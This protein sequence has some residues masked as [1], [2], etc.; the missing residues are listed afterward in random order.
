MKFIKSLLWVLFIMLVAIL[1]F[2]ITL[3]IVSANEEMKEIE[4][5]KNQVIFKSFIDLEEEN[6]NN[7]NN[8]E[9]MTD[10]VDMSNFVNVKTDNFIFIGGSRFESLKDLSDNVDFNFIEFITSKDFDCDWLRNSALNDLNKLLHNSSESYN[11]V[12]NIGI[13]DFENVDRY[14]QFLNELADLHP[15]H[16]VFVVDVAPLDEYKFSAYY[17]YPINNDDIYNFNISLKKSLNQNVKMIYSYK[18]LIINGYNS[19][20]GY[21][22][23]KDTSIKLLQFI[24]DTILSFKEYSM[25][26]EEIQ[27]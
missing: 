9:N 26:L 27:E 7:T 8:Q 13:N 1:T 15:N 4:R 17:N 12:F 21:Y 22:F 14:A 25:K 3:E 10:V 11:I 20:D 16:N 5:Q 18:E 19:V 24:R 2:S 6:Y 23:D